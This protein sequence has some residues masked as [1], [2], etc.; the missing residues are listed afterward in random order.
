M[1]LNRRTIRVSHVWI[2]TKRVGAVYLKSRPFIPLTEYGGVNIAKVE[3]IMLATK[4]SSH[5][6]FNIDELVLPPLGLYFICATCLDASRN[7]NSK[8]QT[9]LA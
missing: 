2:Y 7:A 1:I 8:A 3:E 9:P 6:E 4:P 5:N